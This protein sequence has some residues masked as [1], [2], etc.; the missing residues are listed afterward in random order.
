[1]SMTVTDGD[2]TKD[3]QLDLRPHARVTPTPA[4]TIPAD[5]V[6]FAQQ[7]L[8]FTPDAIQAKILRSPS[9]RIMLCM[10]RRSGKT[11][12]VAARAA[13]F[14]LPHPNSENLI[15]SSSQRQ[16]DILLR[17]IRGFLSKLSIRLLS[18][19][20]GTPSLRLPNGAIFVSLP[21]RPN[22]IVGFTPSLIILDEASRIPDEL[23]FAVSPMLGLHEPSIILLSTPNGRRGFF[24]EN[25]I[26][27]DPDWAR[28]LAPTT[29]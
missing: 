8:H 6:D 7:C 24:Y 14:A 26:S 28:F 29:E 23:Y 3:L 16:A 5:A 27:G 12:A 17:L 22:T 4:Q 9:P 15:F 11:Y 10:G 20:G 2:W 25:W 13:H 18:A 1:M 21:P 19:G